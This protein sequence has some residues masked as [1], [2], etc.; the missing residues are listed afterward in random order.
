MR[1]YLGVKGLSTCLFTVST[2]SL[3][4]IL[5]PSPASLQ[6]Q[7]PS[8]N[9]L[10]AA[11]PVVPQLIRYSGVSA[12]RAGE[13]VEAKFSVY[14]EQ[15]GGEPLWSETQR[16][17]VGTDGKFSVLLGAATEGGLPQ[18][19]F[20]AGQGQWLAV[21]I[22]RADEA[23]EAARVKL[24]SVAYAM[25]AADAE[26]LAGLP[27]EQFVTQRQLAATAAALTAQASRKILPDTTPS[28]SGTANYLA[29]WTGAAT[30]G[31]SAL[32][33]WGTPTTP[34][35]GINSTTPEATLD[36]NGAE[37]VRGTLIMVP[38]GTATAS[39]ATN[40]P[41]LAFG[42]SSFDSATSKPITISY[43]W[44]V[45][46]L[47]NN[48]ATP[49]AKLNLMYVYGSAAAKWTGI[50][51]NPQGQIVFAPGQTFP[52]TGTITGVTA[53]TGLT[54]GGT[55]GAVSLAV[56]PAALETTFN[57][58]Y[59]GLSSA[60]NLFTGSATFGGP[61]GV[62]TT[63]PGTSAI[64][65]GSASG[66]GVVGN[67][68]APDVG[69]SGVLGYVTSSLSP[70]YTSVSNAGTAGVWGDASG[71]PNGADW[72]A[73]VV[74]T[75][76]SSVGYGG[77]FYNNSS[78]STN[79]TGKPGVLAGNAGSGPGLSAV[80]EGGGIGVQ[81][82]SNGAGTGVE[83]DSVTPAPGQAGVFGYTGT[84]Q[85]S[86]YSFLASTPGG[87]GVAGM[88]G[89]STGNPTSSYWSAGVVGTSAGNDAYGGVFL[90][91][92][93]TGGIINENNIAVFAQ[94]YRAS[95]QP[96]GTGGN[97]V[98]ASTLSPAPG[99]AGV[100]GYAYKTS[101]MYDN[102]T[103]TGPVGFV[104]GVWGD[105]GEVNDGTGTYE[106][107]IVGTGDD[108]TAAVFENNSPSGHP[109][110]S[111]INNHSGGPTGLFKTLFA[112]SP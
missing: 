105:A 54:G 59:A 63:G 96:A 52:G 80:S 2:L 107:G 23:G 48:T 87:N 18:A 43:G 61:V 42:A 58:V 84:G 112:A 10:Q 106:A 76:G 25:K 100:L 45:V 36:V 7:E 39:G 78:S 37:I 72:G 17:Q 30:L 98:L 15:R 109:T 51:I 29:Y 103:Y 86:L 85:S 75:A 79:F 16:I 92:N 64:T 67:S 66:S 68:V 44:Q 8:S 110:V 40:S 62:Q 91:E 73:G 60:N 81:G 5:A 6:A 95:T 12:N 50:S 33:Q 69:A 22:E 89:D 55:S 94:N 28:G 32:Y 21:S 1:G 97:G 56:N 83:G 9:S 77:F 35:I 38:A 57:S 20:S 93:T 111:A 74:G 41:M 99:N 47:G 53:G 34:L 4:L 27:V 102:V 19:V 3:L 108:I 26:T 24:A 31:N 13:T 11:T 82:T 49:Y 101:I 90:A 65:G 104:A 14:A 88:W 70:N 46:G 71:A